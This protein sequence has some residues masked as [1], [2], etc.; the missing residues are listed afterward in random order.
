MPR[1][2]NSRSRV[3]SDLKGSMME[4]DLQ[5]FQFTLPRGERRPR[6][7]RGPYRYLVSIHAPAWGATGRDYWKF[8]DTGVSIHAPAWGATNKYQWAVKDMEFQFTLPRGERPAGL[9]GGPREE[10]FQFTLPRGERQRG[11]SER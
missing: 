9:L 7:C 5:E 2:F 6:A 3:G 1:C 10:G 8:Y 4:R 11:T